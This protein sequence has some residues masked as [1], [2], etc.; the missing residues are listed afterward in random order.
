M[1]GGHGQ[2]AAIELAILAKA[3]V[4]G[5]AK[6][7]LIPHLGRE[8]A[9]AL[10]RWLLRR[11]VRVAV[12]ADLGPVSLWCA[13]DTGHPDFERC[14]ASGE[15]RLLSQPQ[16][17]LGVRMQAAAAASRTPAGML[18]IGTDCPVLTPVLIRRVARALGQHDAVVVPAEDGGYVL[19][20]LR[21]ADPRLFADIDWSTDRVMEQTRE[22]LRAL[23]LRWHEPAALWDVDRPEDFERLAALSPAVRAAVAPAERT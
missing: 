1:S 10:Q 6:T 15:V 21:R 16:G 4:A 20:A 2:P 5:F 22:R 13:P 7:R 19:I 17:D 11:A 18:I 14:L 3:P 12:R 23:G 8:G 9:A